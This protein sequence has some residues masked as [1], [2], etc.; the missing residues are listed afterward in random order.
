M[1]L[2]LSKTTDTGPKPFRYFNYWNECEGFKSVIVEAWSAEFIGSPKFH[3]VKKLKKCKQSSQGRRSYNI[4][5]KS[6]INS[7]RQ[8]LKEVHDSMG[9]I[10]SLLIG[11]SQKRSL[12]R[13]YS[14]GFFLKRIK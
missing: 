6:R 4:S 14:I 7:I 10:L 5:I 3:L 9:L 13:S 2:H 8:Q 11:R 12:S 1:L